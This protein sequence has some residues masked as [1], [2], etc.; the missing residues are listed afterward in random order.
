[1]VKNY[2]IKKEFVIYHILTNK[3]IANTIQSNC[4]AMCKTYLNVTSGIL[5]FLLFNSKLKKKK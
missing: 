4:K 2:N 1:M 5:R 3:H